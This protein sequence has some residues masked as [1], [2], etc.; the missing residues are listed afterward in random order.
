MWCEQEEAIKEGDAAADE[1]VEGDDDEDEDEEEE[2]EYV[3]E[4][5]LDFDAVLTALLLHVAFGV[6][7]MLLQ[8]GQKFGVI[9][10]GM[11][12]LACK[13]CWSNPTAR[14]CP[15]LQP[16]LFCINQEAA[17]QQL[18]SRELNGNL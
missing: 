11:S 1:Y 14:Q 7:S 13:N 15:H 18:R 12:L 8:G 6:P 10:D 9:T 5:D 16:S 2:V 3:N 17:V 4:E